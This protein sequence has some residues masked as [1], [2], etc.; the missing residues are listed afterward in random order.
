MKE[1]VSFSMREREL[2]PLGSQLG[3]SSHG[4]FLRRNSNSCLPPPP[5]NAPLST[6][7]GEVNSLTP[8]SVPA[9]MKN[10][11]LEGFLLAKHKHTNIPTMMEQ[12]APSAA[13]FCWLSIPYPQEP[14]WKGLAKAAVEGI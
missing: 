10:S 8:K 6:H 13:W 7:R 1:K 11:R 3:M 14:L 12:F 5:R 9:G 4:G 2:A